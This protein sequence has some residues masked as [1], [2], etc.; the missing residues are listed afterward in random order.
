MIDISSFRKIGRFKIFRQGDLVCMQNDPGDTM[1]VVLRG[2]FGVYINSFTDFPIRVAGIPAG[3]FFGEMSVIDGWPRSATIISEEL[4][5]SISISQENFIELIGNNR[6]IAE[7]I[8]G[9]LSGRAA[10]TADMA[11][12]KGKNVAELPD[13]LENPVLCE[14]STKNHDTMLKLAFRI[15]ELNEMLGVGGAAAE[16]ELKTAL[17][18]VNLFP[19]W[20]KRFTEPDPN[21]N[22]KILAVWEYVCPYC[23]KGFKNRIPL[24]S[25]LKEKQKT[26]DY[27]V[28]YDS[29]DILFYTN[30]VCPNCTY[31]DTYQE[32]QKEHKPRKTPKVEGCQFPSE[33]GFTGYEDERQHT[34]DEALLSYYLNLECLK[35]I[36]GSELRQAKAW[37]KLYWI[38]QD[39]K[40]AKA[41]KYAAQ[42]A[43][44]QYQRYQQRYG[45][46][47]ATEDYMTINI[48]VGELYASLAD[49]ENARKTYIKNT[50]IGGYTSHE[51]AIKSIK[52]IAD[53]KNMIT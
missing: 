27:R 41:E 34:L 10:S 28:V 8:L 53:F 3:A 26:L 52:R 30:I 6:A 9:T 19:K 24:F 45:D 4:G 23:G 16:I 11:R 5:L 21:D 44:K 20:H 15:R 43:L 31:C 40:Y 50:S 25:R 12:K 33:E 35:Q 49:Y 48:I 13:E 39:Q 22:S 42:K 1:Y 17:V 37:H 18:A 46:D 2:I 32:F 38:Y 14:D 7:K 29:F 47:L 51:L 36:P